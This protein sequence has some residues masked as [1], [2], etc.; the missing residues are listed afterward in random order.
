MKQH[1]YVTL[2]VGEGWETSLVVR[3]ETTNKL[4]A[5]L[6]NYDFCFILSKFCFDSSHH[7][8]KY[9]QLVS[10]MEKANK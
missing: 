6:I 9:F 10:Y 4:I 2:E 7:T 1:D 3:N 8:K 5:I